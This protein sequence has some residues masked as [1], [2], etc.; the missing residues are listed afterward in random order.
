MWEDYKFG[1][2]ENCSGNEKVEKIHKVLELFNNEELTKEYMYKVLELWPY[3]CEHNLTN[4]SL[5]KIAYIGQAA[6][7]IYAKVPNTVTME[8]WSLLEKDIQDRSDKIAK[9]VIEHWK[10]KNRFIQLCLKLD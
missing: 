3:S 6:C 7:C 1:F 4:E 9:E 10:Y 2:Y 5:N 8:A